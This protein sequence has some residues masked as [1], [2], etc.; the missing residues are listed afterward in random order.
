MIEK[1]FEEIES[2]YTCTA[3]DVGDFKDVRVEGAKIQVAAYD[4][5]E[6]GRMSTVSVRGFLGLWKMQSV[7]LNPM[8]VDMPIYYYHR[9][10][11]KGN[12][13]CM[14][15]IIDTFLNKREMASLT[16]VLDQY[17]SI[18]DLEV[19]ENW[20]DEIKLSCGFLKSVKK[21]EE[22]VLDELTLAH[23]REY[24]K[25]AEIAPKCGKTRKKEAASDFVEG[26]VEQSGIAVLQLFR[27]YYD[28]KVA[29]KL[30]RD[31]LFGMK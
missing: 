28:K 16:A 13:L 29:T 6:F 2:K 22:A 3:V 26:L 20:Y 5:E 9:H 8:E 7:I 19:K 17:K 1:I 4:V 31:I 10:D 12:E 30:C 11:K 18:P 15:E 21:S 27:S 25:L 24:L 14:V 23:L